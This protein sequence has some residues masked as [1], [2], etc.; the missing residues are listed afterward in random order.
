L[1]LV[2]SGSMHSSGDEGEGGSRRMEIMIFKSVLAVPIGSAHSPF[3]RR[4]SR[5]V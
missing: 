2:I 4:R 3:D 5:F 1:P